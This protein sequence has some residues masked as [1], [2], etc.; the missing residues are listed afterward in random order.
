MTLYL[1]NRKHC[2][3]FHLTLNKND[4]LH[5]GMHPYSF[6]EFLGIDLSLGC[7]NVRPRIRFSHVF[8]RIPSP[9]AVCNRTTYSMSSG[10]WATLCV[11]SGEHSCTQQKKLPWL[12]RIKKLLKVCRPK[13]LPV[14]AGDV[15][16]LSSPVPPSLASRLLSS[17]ALPNGCEM[18]V[19]L[20]ASC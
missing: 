20:Q 18:A 19:P 12:Q 17:H 14:M 8:F 5:C 11:S 2:C 10:L 7:R 3:P 15:C 9:L 13:Q 16:T 4:S 1:V 6:S